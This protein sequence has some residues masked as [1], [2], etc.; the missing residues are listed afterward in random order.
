[1]PSNDLFYDLL[2]RQSREK[3]INTDGV[4]T[5]LKVLES[6]WRIR[7]FDG[8]L[9]VMGLILTSV[10]AIL[11]GVDEE[12]KTIHISITKT[13]PT[14]HVLVTAKW[15][16]ML[17]FVY[18]PVSNAIAFSYVAAS[19]VAS[20]AVQ[21]SK[22]MTETVLVVLD[23]TIMGLLLS[24]NG[25]AIAVGVLGQYGNSR[26]QWRRVCNMLGGFCH[27]MTAAIILSLVASSIFFWLAA[28]VILN[29][30][31]KSR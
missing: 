29:L 7:Y 11:T 22:D 19:L 24:A 30:H 4:E 28:L 16:Y 15:H 25:A 27:Q 12:T 10:A 21:T 6:S 1:M 2:I 13:L 17:A 23:M 5:N 31:K 14:L 26:V 9:R 8:L 18:F 20:M 3:G